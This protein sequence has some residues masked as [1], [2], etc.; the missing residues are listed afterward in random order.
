MIVYLGSKVKVFHSKSILFTYKL[1][2]PVENTLHSH[3]QE[4]IN[5]IRCVTRKKF[6]IFQ[7]FH[8]SINFKNGINHS[9]YVLC[10]VARNGCTVPYGVEWRK[11]ELTCSCVCRQQAAMNFL[12]NNCTMPQGSLSK[13]R[14]TRLS[15]F[16]HFV[17]HKWTKRQLIF[18]TVT[19]S[20]QISKCT[21]ILV[22]PDTH[23]CQII[24]QI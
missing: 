9:R 2:H 6:C 20:I 1:L 10:T 18:W 23:F 5:S 7:L 17:G 13:F 16:L 14:L 21:Y 8:R 4:H 24:W 22:F 15:E 11:L 19:Q 3:Y 12:F